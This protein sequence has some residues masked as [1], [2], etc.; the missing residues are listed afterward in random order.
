MRIKVDLTKLTRRQREVLTALARR[1]SK[2]EIEQLV[3][4]TTRSGGV[5]GEAVKQA[6]DLLKQPSRNWSAGTPPKAGKP[7]L[8]SPT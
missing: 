4:A 1:L 7:L 6:V 8:A 5:I 3:E 2:N